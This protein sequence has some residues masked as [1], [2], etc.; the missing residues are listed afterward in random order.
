[1]LSVRQESDY[2]RVSLHRM[3]L[4]APQNVMDALA[5]YIRGKDKVVALSVREFIEKKVRQLN[6]SHQI[7]PEKMLSQGTVYN[8]QKIY[9][10]LNGL[11]FKNQVKVAITWFGKTHPR[12]RSRVTLGL[13]QESLKLIKVNRLLDCPSVPDYMISF[14]VYHE[15][16][17]HIY[18]SYYDEKGVFQ[19]H[20]KEFRKR[21]EQFSHYELAQNWLAE[22]HN[23]LFH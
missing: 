4:H 11:Y 22:H 12:Y 18:P 9:L 5:C 3:F 23:R 10:E 2:V 15:M 8:L 16:L 17:H 19:L 14:V 7:D 21:E 1:M 13:Y 20:S 6:Y